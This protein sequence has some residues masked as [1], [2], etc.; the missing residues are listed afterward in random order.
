[1]ALAK[2]HWSVEDLELLSRKEL[3]D[4]AK[5]W[6]IR[7]NKKNE[8]I[9]AELLSLSSGGA[10][11][12]P[13]ATE[14][15]SVMTGEEED[16]KLLSLPKAHALDGI[17]SLTVDDTVELACVRASF[18][19][20]W[21]SISGFAAFEEDK[22]TTEGRGKN[23][24]KIMIMRRGG[25]SFVAKALR[26]QVMYRSYAE[27]VVLTNE[28]QSASDALLIL[29]SDDQ[30]FAPGD[31]NNI[32]GDVKIPVFLTSKDSEQYI[33]PDSF[34]EIFVFDAETLEEEII[35]ENKIK[36]KREKPEKKIRELVDA[37]RAD[38]SAGSAERPTAQPREDTRAPIGRVEERRR[39]AP[40][41][42]GEE[43]RRPAPMGPGEERRRPA[44]GSD[45]REVA[46]LGRERAPRE[47][48][49]SSQMP[50]DKPSRRDREPPAERRERVE[51]RPG[52]AD[53]SRRPR[54]VDRSQLEGVTLK[55]MVTWLATDIGYDEMF[56][57]TGIRCFGNDPSLSSSL[58]FLRK[59]ENEWGR[60][61][62]EDLY[63]EVMQSRM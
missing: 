35:Q 30:L 41:E 56:Q 10:S 58:K 60:K 49:S 43:R 23:S 33:Q 37:E 17:G 38:A 54:R 34:L 18:G 31:P 40:M 13:I 61:K 59:K 20:R 7:A 5:Q 36:P 8:E 26:A 51:R 11:E 46:S 53:S 12:Q 57:R 25:E 15:N 63:L 52:N 22:E 27:P 47:A 4:L 6:G 19:P 42:P 1:M 21:T 29:N 45:M 39:P 28:Q 55:D 50:M 2:V 44:A 48:R 16:Q 3:Q 62:I 32:G 14:D 9:R 24:R